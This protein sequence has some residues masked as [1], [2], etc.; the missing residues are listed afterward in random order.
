MQPLSR[1]DLLSLEDYAEQRAEWR[2]RVMTHKRDRIV[3]LGPNA[4]LYFEDR[5]TMQYQIQEML[6]AEKIF[7]ADGIREELEVYN[8]L[9]P[10][11]TD[12]RATFMLEY[13]DVEQRKAELARLVGIENALWLRAGEHNPITPIANED[14]ERSTEDKTASVHFV[15]FV[16]RSE[17]IADLQGGALL[18]FGIDH[19]N[20]QATVS[21]VPDHIRQ[22]LVSDLD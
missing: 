9:I 5:V 4:R 8:A 14:L 19:E 20:Y 15:R 17:M 11:G 2:Q 16:L 12:M 18:A 3:D 10:N 1:A 13:A 21:P 22:S 7:D 6:R